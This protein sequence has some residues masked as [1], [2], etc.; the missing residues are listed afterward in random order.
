M[1]QQIPAVQLPDSKAGAVSA[2]R[3]V[4]L[5]T[6]FQRF[7]HWTQFT[8]I[9][10]LI[11]TGFEIH[12]T[13]VLFGYQQASFIHRVAAVLLIT[14]TA[15]AIFW[16]F[17]TGEW[18]QYIP[19]RRGIGRTLRHYLRGI[20]LNEPHPDQKTV[21]SRLNPLQ[22]IVYAGFK[23]LILPVI[24][25]SG[26]L[27]MTNNYWE[28]WGVSGLSLQVVA[29]VHVFAALTLIAFIIVHV[30]MT[31]TGHTPFAHIRSMVTG[32]C[33]EECV[34]DTPNHTRTG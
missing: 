20:F 28:A 29:F 31:T 23:V 25:T 10:S 12:G 14:L 7:W 21:K 24:A 9:A 33:D 16:H 34:D 19:Q 15:F 18:R 1:A 4:R 22:R 5:Y 27:Y 8:L 2:R 6:T 11:V 13:Y 26:F 3:R 17:A 30:Y 32:W